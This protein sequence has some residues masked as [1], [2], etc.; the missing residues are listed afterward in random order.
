[1]RNKKLLTAMAVTL[2]LLASGLTQAKDNYNRVSL[3]AEA[4]L[5][6]AH[7]LMQVVLYTE[8]Q[9]TDAARL[10]SEVTRTLN[11]A[12]N[13][14]KQATTVKA[15]L[16]SRYS[17]PVQKE[18]SREIIAWRERAEIRLESTD[19][20][21]LAELTGQLLQQMNMASMSFSVAS[22]TRIEQENQLIATAIA[23][24]EQ[25]ARLTSQALGASD[26]KLVSLSLNT[27]GGY[28]PPVYR[29]A[30]MLSAPAEKAHATPQIE[31]GSSEIKILAEG[32]IEVVKQVEN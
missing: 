5:E 15:S 13:A 2:T 31:A 4:S 24:F 22:T 26:Y 9:D 6:V 21:E 25:R 10:A 29:Q 30:V 19:F 7:D 28:A 3:R 23:A 17:Q 16:A 18:K 14:S 12:L 1:M 27:Q 32:V 20:S 8:Q 11:Q